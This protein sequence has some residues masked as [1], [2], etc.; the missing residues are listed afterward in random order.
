MFMTKRAHRKKVQRLENRIADLENHVMDL[1]K[2]LGEAHKTFED[3]SFRRAQN[4]LDHLSDIVEY[5]TL[6]YAVIS[7]LKACAVH[8]WG[9]ELGKALWPRNKQVLSNLQD[10]EDY[11]GVPTAPKR[12]DT[13]DTPCPGE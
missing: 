2:R 12:S 5:C 13:G 11:P 9:H 4:L 6:D 3:A 1:R 10:L 7:K 8:Y